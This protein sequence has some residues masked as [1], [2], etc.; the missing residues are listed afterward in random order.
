M[1][2]YFPWGQVTYPRTT[3]KDYFRALSQLFKSRKVTIGRKCEW[4]TLW[5]F[6]FMPWSQEWTAL[7]INKI[8]MLATVKRFHFLKFRPGYVSK[9][10][11]IVFVCVIKWW[12]VKLFPN[13][14]SIRFDYL[15]ILW[16]TN[17]VSNRGFLTCV[18]D[19]IDRSWTPLF[20]TFRAKI[21]PKFSEF[22][23][24][25]PLRILLDVLFRV[26]RFSKASF[27]APTSS[28]ITF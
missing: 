19:R 10:C 13:L 23:H 6:L 9:F 24:N 22:F 11:S 12:R 5:L 27:Y 8:L 17:Y 25:I 26:F 21:W 28:F 3:W 16:V 1:K 2:S 14:T 7:I 4:K 20:Q 15:L 18:Q